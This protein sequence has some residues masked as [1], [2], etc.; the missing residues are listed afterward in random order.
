MK[1]T[2]FPG[3]SIISSFF[4]L[5]KTWFHRFEEFSRD[6]K[7][8]GFFSKKKLF[9]SFWGVWWRFCRRLR[10]N[11]KSCEKYTARNE[12]VLRRVCVVY[13]SHILY[14]FQKR[15]APPP[16]RM[17]CEEGRVDSHK[18]WCWRKKARKAKK[19][20]RKGA[21]L[22]SRLFSFLFFSLLLQPGILSSW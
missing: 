4:F 17:L 14:S 11:Q 3:Y 19:K 16:R 15:R 21:C 5:K 22:L 13:R 2:S 18:S 7:E 10:E 8:V 9:S 6:S 12:A 1:K 20:K